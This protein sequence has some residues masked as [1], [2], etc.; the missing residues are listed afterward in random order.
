MPHGRSVSAPAD[1]PVLTA[2]MLAGL[3]LPHSC[4]AG[5]CGSCRARLLSGRIEYPDGPP[6]GLS[7]Q[8]ARQGYVLLCQAR[9]RTDLVVEARLV[10]RTEAVEIGTVSARIV[11]RVQMA[12]D[13]IQLVLRVPAGESMR[14]EPGQHLDVLLEGGPRRSYWVANAAQAGSSLELHVRIVPGGRFS[15]GL[16]GTLREG[17]TLAIEGPIG[18]FVYRGDA[19]PVIFIAGGTGFAAIKAM[20]GAALAEGS[21]HELHLYRGAGDLADVYEEAL[22]RDWAG[23][24][25][26]LRVHPHRAGALHEAVLGEH[27][28]L[29]PF[30]VYAAGPPAMIEAIR[31][32]FPARGAQPQQLHLDASCASSS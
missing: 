20:L 22:V 16:L 19:R 26:R 18:E 15:E 30:A 9:A 29:A 12:A 25:G 1:L 21:T 8:E 6:P 2:A 5:R 27:A 13:V 23:R 4:R 31:Q 32:T 17:A 3:P 11:R 7:A 10:G 24:H 28:S 14:F